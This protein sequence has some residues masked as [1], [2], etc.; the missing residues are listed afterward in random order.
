MMALPQLVLLKS[1]GT[2]SKIRVVWQVLKPQGETNMA[3]SPEGLKKLVAIATDL[4]LSAK[5]RAGAIEQIGNVA[6]HD[7]LL[8]LL[9]LAGNESLSVDER[10]LAL[11]H[12]REIIKRGR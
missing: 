8:Q 1:A 3:E 9:S 12:A 5:L 10:E 11:K 4:E 7:A 2:K 6:T